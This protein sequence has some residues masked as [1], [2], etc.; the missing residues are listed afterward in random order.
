MV[1]WLQSR[2]LFV[3]RLSYRKALWY[4]VDL[5]MSES[6]YHCWNF[7]PGQTLSLTAAEPPL[8]TKCNHPLILLRLCQF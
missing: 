4:A 1:T 3:T 8:S 2:I 7:K 5:D 6:V